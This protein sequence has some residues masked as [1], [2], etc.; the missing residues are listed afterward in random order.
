MSKHILM[1]LGHDFLE[2]YIDPRVYKEAKS[3]MNMGH[4]VKILC[5]SDT[6][7]NENYEGIEVV[8]VK[9]IVNA[10]KVIKTYTSVGFV[11]LL[12]DM[13][14]TLL[15]AFVRGL[16]LKYNTIH[17]HDLD[18]LPLGV[19]MKITKPWKKLTYDSHELTLGMPFKPYMRVIVKFVERLCLPFVHT[20][21]TANEARLKIMKKHYPLLL[22]KKKCVVVHNY[23]HPTDLS[24]VNE[25]Q[26]PKH[27]KGKTIFVYQGPLDRNRGITQI[28]TAFISLK[29]DDWALIIVGGKDK[30]IKDFKTQFP[31]K[32]ILFTGFVHNTEVTRYMKAADIGILS[33]RNTCL[34]NYY[35]AHNKLYEYM[36]CECA[37]LG[38]EFPELQPFILDNHIGLTTDFDKPGVIQEALSKFIK[39]EK[40][41]LRKMQIHAKGLAKDYLWE[42]NE[43]TLKAI[44]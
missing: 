42:V 41:K 16:F 26:L 17:C 22:K 9:R 36:Q 8:R 20:L 14:I 1:I 31:N 30:Q 21:I 38:P 2:P 18:T 34:N 29:N 27:F 43:P 28:L 23:P 39:K 24:K 33:L 10:K 7:G 4:K 32:N 3:L 35:A 11:L 37:I 40:T 6:R 15:K 5:F 44:M 25:P 12:I 19:I 13:P